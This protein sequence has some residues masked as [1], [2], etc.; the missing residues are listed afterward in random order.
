LYVWGLLG[1]AEA[2][3]EFGHFA[4]NLEIYQ[5]SRRG[6]TI[7]RASRQHVSAAA[8]PTTER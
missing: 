7:I 4:G 1:V 8:E 6:F 3:W 2:L 5:E